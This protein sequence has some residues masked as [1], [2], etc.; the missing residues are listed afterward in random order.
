MP[1]PEAAATEAGGLALV[2]AALLPWDSRRSM[3]NLADGATVVDTMF[4]P[5]ALRRLR[6]VK[7]HHDPDGV[8]LANHPVI[9]SEAQE[10]AVLTVPG[11]SSGQR[12]TGC[13][14]ASPSASGSVSGASMGLRIRRKARTPPSAQRATQI[15]RAIE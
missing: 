3:M 7:N 2:R 15:Q 1:T 4:P 6:A 5:G 8:L 10:P 14:S 12:T 13:S 9:P 11:V